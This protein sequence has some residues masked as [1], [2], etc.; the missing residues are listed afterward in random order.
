MSTLNRL[1]WSCE[2]QSLGSVELELR[3][4][5]REQR[6]GLRVWLAKRPSRQMAGGG[7]KTAVWSNGR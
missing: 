3:A 6:P 2:C 4:L 5:E 7:K 1:S